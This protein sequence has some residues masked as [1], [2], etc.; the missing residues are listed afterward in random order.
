MQAQL[1]VVSTSAYFGDRM[2]SPY[3]GR[4]WKAFRAEVIELDDERCRRCKRGIAE[5][6]VLQVHHLRY[7]PRKRPWEYSY[8]D[9]ETLCKSCH[10]Q[11]HGHVRPSFGW[12]YVGDDDLGELSGT[13]D[14]CGTE[15]R[16]VFHIQHPSWEPLEVGT[17]CCDNLTG[18]VLAS[19]HM[20]SLRRFQTRQSRFL[21]SPRWQKEMNSSSIR[22]KGNDITIL[23]SGSVFRIVMNKKMGRREFSTLKAAKEA[24]FE[25][26][27][28]GKAEQYFNSI[29]KKNGR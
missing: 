11:L 26:I 3:T 5:G 6:V 8:S 24:V 23:N 18:T 19:N 1:A 15:I 2:S 7:S 4:E 21:E 29:K 12:D 20:E 16:Y 27:E 22:Q 17:I 10:A 28:N 25:V 14:Y 9:C 13:C